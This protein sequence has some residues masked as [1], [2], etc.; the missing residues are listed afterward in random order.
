ME[1]IQ[2]KKGNVHTFTF[3]EDSFNFAYKDK[4][5]S[6]DTDFQYADFPRKSSIQIEQ[7]EWLRNVGVLWCAIGV[8]QYGYALYLNDSSYRNAFWL[9]VGVVCLAWYQSSKVI[10]SVF[11]AEHGNI[12][13]IHDKNH[14]RIIEELTSR[15]KKQL[16][17]WY[18]DIDPQNEMQNEIAKF[19]WLA[20]QDVISKEECENKVAQVEL[21]H[22]DASV[23]AKPLN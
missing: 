22:R 16:L 5:G 2:K 9:F 6:G 10:Y 21:L 3:Q 4:Q 11:R 12:F 17:K 15:R 7:N 23:S 8:F 20:E 18:G 1:I 13:I 14:D 19:K